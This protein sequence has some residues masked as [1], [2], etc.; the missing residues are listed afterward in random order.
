MA[1]NIKDVAKRAGVSSAAVSYV[2]NGRLD[3]LS[4]PTIERIRTA[5]AELDYEPSAMARGLVKQRSGVLG[6]LGSHLRHPVE[7]FIVSA[8][9]VA[10]RKHEMNIL[11]WDRVDHQTT[12]PLYITDQ[13]RQL[14]AQRADGVLTSIRLADEHLARLANAGVP[15]VV[16][17]SVFPKVDNVHSDFDLGAELAIAHLAAQERRRLVYLGWNY[18]VVAQ[19]VERALAAHPEIR[20]VERLPDCANPLHACR[21]IASLIA[22]GTAFDAVFAVSDWLASGVYRACEA[23]GLAIPRDVAV[24]G[25]DDTFAGFFS[26]PLTS[27]SQSFDQ[28]A[29][30]AVRRLLE[31]IDA[32]ARLRTELVRG[33]P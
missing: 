16:Y 7:S 9:V 32:P 33:A 24:V 30:Q 6:V 25:F 2:L 21:Q 5:I 31:R 26:P 4:A 23:A 19:G 27:I 18:Q 20:L 22:R 12:D 14:I 1:A 15:T 3:Q 10:A 29:E 28:I 11:I 13:I 17:D 8:L